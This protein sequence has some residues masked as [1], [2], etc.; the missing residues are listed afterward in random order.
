[1]LNPWPNFD[2]EEVSLVSNVLKSGDINYL[3]GAEGKS[4]EKE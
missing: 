4:F 1:M 2:E 3:Y